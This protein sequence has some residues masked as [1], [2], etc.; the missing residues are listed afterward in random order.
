MSKRRHSLNDESTSA[1]TVISSW[2]AVPGLIPE[3][4]IV[5]AFADKAKRSKKKGSDSDVLVIE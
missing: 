2:A 5:S 1:A 3:A 4:A